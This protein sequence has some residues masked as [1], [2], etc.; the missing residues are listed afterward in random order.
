[1]DKWL[2]H[3][4]A[5]KI[6]A[7]LVALLLWAIVHLDPDTTP[8]TVTSTVDVKVIEAAKIIP[9]GLDTERFVLTGMEPTVVRIDVQGRI[10]D[11]L[12]ASSDEDYVVSVNL[13]KAKAGIQ[14]LPLE[15]TSMPRGIEVL[16]ISPRTVTVQV[17]EIVT[18]QF[19][20][21]ITTT[22]NPADGYIAGVPKVNPINQV[23]LTLPMEDMSRV[24]VVTAEVDINDASKTVVNKKTKITV[25]DKDGI[26]MVNATTVPS[27]L[28]IEVPVTPPFK[29]IPL[30][31]GFTGTL[32]AGIS[33]VSASPEDDKIMVYAE[34]SILDSLQVY[35]GAVLDLSKVKESG[36]VKVKA[37]LIDGI[38]MVGSEEINV[39]V[40]VSPTVTRT[41]ADTS[42]AITGLAEGLEAKLVTPESGK[43]DLVLSGSESVLAALKVSDVHVEANT[44]GLAPGVHEVPLQVTVPMFVDAL[45]SDT[46]SLSVT[47]E[48]IDTTASEG[49]EE[50]AVEAG[51]GAGAGD[52]TETQTETETEAP[53]Q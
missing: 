48:I 5:I 3:P 36:Q 18:Q 12:K 50:E 42:I 38:K 28:E 34:Q 33:L 21:Q 37:G 16:S 9:Q 51:A 10:S 52:G 45:K 14:E 53:E 1:M 39:Q 27:T 11:L 6:V 40:T 15:V 22:G 17:E 7:V 25:Y 31:L 23:S 46:Q 20:V 29:S 26:E 35:D 13:S 41:I 44:Q 19:E 32:P 30:Q 49:I 4:T 8:A 43:L 47:I 2:S 24:G